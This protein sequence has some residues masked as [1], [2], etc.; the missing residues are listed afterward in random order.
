MGDE[1]RMV[2]WKKKDGRIIETNAEEATIL[3]ATKAGWVRQ[4]EKASKADKK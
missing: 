1:I 4:A 3:A 2:K